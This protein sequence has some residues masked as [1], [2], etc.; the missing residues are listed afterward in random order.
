MLPYNLLVA[1][2][3]LVAVFVLPQSVR[4][5]GETD[6]PF[7]L[8]ELMQYFAASY[9]Q[10][11]NKFT[12]AAATAGAEVIRLPLAAKGNSGL[13]LS[14]DIAWF[15]S[16]KPRKILLHTSGLHGVEGFAGSAIQLALV[17]QLPALPEDSALV[18][19][20][21]LNPYGMSMLRR[22]N[23]SN[24]DL[25]RN[26]LS[27]AGDFR[28]SPQAYASLDTFL[29]P[30]APPA[31][32]FFYLRVAYHYLRLGADTLVKAVAAGQHDFPRGLFFA[33]HRLEQGPAVYRAWLQQH[34][35]GAEQIF[36]IDVHTGLGDFARDSLFHKIGHTPTAQL[37]RILHQPVLE[38]FP[39]SQVVGYRFPGG[40]CE[41]IK[42]L[43]A[44]KRVDFLTQEFGTYSKLKI[45]KALRDENRYHHYGAGDTTHWSKQQLKEAF[46]P[47][48][49]GWRVPVVSNGIRLVQKVATMLFAGIPTNE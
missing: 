29:N 39:E 38:N 18:L 34:L 49:E 41:V 44:D 12:Q 10:A 33:G 8:N 20:H 46:C 37:N 15:G 7:L 13:P 35:G 25:N 24:V 42:E 11:R 6:Q 26:F 2:Y 5:A 1:L 19:V 3:V 21:C 16:K 45:L 47:S 30:P 28:G 36:V 14:I 40:H 23:E 43:F 31:K 17:D 48:D 27:S 9:D 22:Y 4:T 32:D